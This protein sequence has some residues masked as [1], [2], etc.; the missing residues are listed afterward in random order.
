MGFFQGFNFDTVLAIISCITGIV[1]LFLGGTAYKNCKISKNTIEQKKEFD[2]GST[3]NSITVGGDYSHNEGISETGLLSVMDKM[4]AMTS[5]SFS[6][7]LDEA[8]TMFQAKCDDNLHRIINEA[9]RIVSEQKLDI[10]GYSKI[11]WI[12]IY[13]EAAK[14]TSDTY[15][16]T[17]WAKVL[18]KE[19]ASPDSFSYKTLDA[20]K[21]MSENEFRLFEKLSAMN[22][23]GA[24]IQ[25]DYLDSHGFTWMT[26]QKLKEYGLIS[27]D[28]SER[29]VG[30]EENGESIQIIN[31]QYLIHF[32]NEKSEK[33]ENIIQCYLLTNV[34][35]E[36]LKVVF[37]NTDTSLARKITK[38]IQEKARGKCIIKLHKINYFYPDGNNFNYNLEDIMEET[39]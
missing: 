5:A 25:G 23:N 31:N 21:N 7:T 10:A 12:H 28:A 8:Y 36:L 15:M 20:L 14:N 24:I 13:F 34:S 30:V 2:D 18:A 32:R 19:L 1:A 17:V 33:V 11:D 16:Q 37:E 22:V 26:L 39:N 35:K 6:A 4:N 9:K 29:T 38:T 27:L 3:D